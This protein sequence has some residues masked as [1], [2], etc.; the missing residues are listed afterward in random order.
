MSN[1]RLSAQQR[2][3]DILQRTTAEGPSTV[4]DL[5][6]RYDVTPSTIRRDLT[7]LGEA[8]LLART[9]GG[10]IAV[11]GHGESSL[12]ERAGEAQAEKRAIAK[13]A[14]DRITAGATLILDAGSTIAAM[15]P[16]LRHREELTVVTPNLQVIND[17]SDEKS[18]V[19]VIAVA[20]R[21]RKLSR[22]FVGALAEATLERVR[23]DIAFL[24]ADSVSADGQL[25]EMETEQTRL[26]EIIGRRVTQV[27]VLA[28]GSKLGRS[29]GQASLSMP[30]SW[31]VVTDESALPEHIEQLRAL[32][33]EVIVA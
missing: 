11:N 6:T 16:H 2:R 24:G 3:Q 19:Q 26:K 22:S 1:P 31:A 17:L 7:R 18:P 14:A 20:G 12:P 21:L 9:Y 8:G 30:P 4:D 29:V 15:T 33:H 5:A 27:Y 28:H 23:G 25:C 32:G 13:L 10:V